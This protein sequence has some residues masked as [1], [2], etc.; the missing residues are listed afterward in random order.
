MKVRVGAQAVPPSTW[1]TLTVGVP[2]VSVAVTTDLTLASVG[3]V[4]LQP[5]L[6]PVGTL[7]KVGAAVSAVQE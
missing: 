6:P 2:Q 1:P 4:G 5:K 7:V 3:S